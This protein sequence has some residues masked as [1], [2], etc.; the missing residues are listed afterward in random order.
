MASQRPWRVERGSELLSPC[1]SVSLLLPSP[2]H[3]CFPIPAPRRPGWFRA[4]AAGVL[5]GREA[6]ERAPFSVLGFQPASLFLD[7]LPSAHPHTCFLPAPSSPL[8]Q[9][10]VGATKAERMTPGLLRP[11]SQSV[12]VSCLPRNRM[13]GHLSWGCN[14]YRG[15]RFGARAVYL[16]ALE[17]GKYS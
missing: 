10:V 17:K 5:V 6:P 3:P 12:Q 8:S 7:G 9:A 16:L 15:A 1:L 4:E 13:R 14:I 2:Q 11:R